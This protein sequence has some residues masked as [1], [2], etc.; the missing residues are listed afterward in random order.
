MLFCNVSVC[1]VCKKKN[2]ETMNGIRK[3][4]GMPIKRGKKSGGSFSEVG[5]KK[6]ESITSYS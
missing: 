4:A 2:K 5:S 6:E 3:A 1:T